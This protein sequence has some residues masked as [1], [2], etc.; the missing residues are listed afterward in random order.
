MDLLTT[1][2]NSLFPQQQS[3]QKSSSAELMHESPSADT[4]N[5]KNLNHGNRLRKKTPKLQKEKQEAL[6]IL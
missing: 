3:S 1:I 4:S 6:Q 2:Y 5:K